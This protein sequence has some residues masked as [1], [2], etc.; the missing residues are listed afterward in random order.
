MN[1]TFSKAIR[2]NSML[3]LVNIS[4]SLDE[5]PALN[6]FSKLFPTFM[7]L[8]TT[9]TQKEDLKEIKMLLKHLWLIIRGLNEKNTETVNY[10]TIDQMNALG[11]L[12]NKVLNLVTS[13]K[14]ESMKLM[15]N[16]HVEIDEED[17][18]LLKEQMAK[19]SAASTYVMEISGQLN[20]NFKET[21]TDM[22]KSNLLN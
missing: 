1:Y 14:A 4:S 5:S 18:E 10:T 20:L 19:L 13:A 7:T 12:M 3:I 16:K 17:L 21:T 11:Q 15:N 2:K 6:I 9:A 22:V 8:I